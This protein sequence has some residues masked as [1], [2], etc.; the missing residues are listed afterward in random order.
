MGT[1][2]VAVRAALGTEMILR[3]YLSATIIDFGSEEHRAPISGDVDD[4][5]LLYRYEVMVS[6]YDISSPASPRAQWALAPAWG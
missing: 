2:T 4:C 3:W 1:G 5:V 6:S